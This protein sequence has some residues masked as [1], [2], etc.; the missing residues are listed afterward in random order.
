MING[1]IEYYHA[2]P[3]LPHVG[4]RGFYFQQDNNSALF[5][6]IPIVFLGIRRYNQISQFETII[7]ESYKTEGRNHEQKI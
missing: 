6:K 3:L 7:F 5:F 1:H 2:S 4:K